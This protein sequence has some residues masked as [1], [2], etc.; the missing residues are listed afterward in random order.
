[1]EPTL[2]RRTPCRH[3]SDTGFFFPNTTVKLFIQKFRDPKNAVVKNLITSYDATYK[4]ASDPNIFTENSSKK[5]MKVYA[6]T[7]LNMPE[8]Y[9]PTQIKNRIYDIDWGNLSPKQEKQNFSNL[10]RYTLRKV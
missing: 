7:S 3:L 6:D 9:F 4:T 1:M 5:E 2:K 10:L 8:T